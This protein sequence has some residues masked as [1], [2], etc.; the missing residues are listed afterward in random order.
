MQ[1]YFTTFIEYILIINICC[2][3]CE[4]EENL[5][6]VTIEDQIN[7]KELVPTQVPLFYKTKKRRHKEISNKIEA[8][9]ICLKRIRSNRIP[10]K[11]PAFK[12]VLK[13]NRQGRGSPESSQKMSSQGA[14]DE[15]RDKT[16][17]IE[18]AVRS[19]NKVCVNLNEIKLKKDSLTCF[20]NELD[21]KEDLA[22][23]SKSHT[24]TKPDSF[25]CT[26]CGK[27]FREK[28]HLAT[29]SRAH[30][31]IRNFKCNEC[32]G[33]FKTKTNLFFHMK[34]HEEAPFI[35]DRCN[36]TFPERKI[37]MRHKRVVHR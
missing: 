25:D 12:K 27:K 2:F 26:V 14:S 34:T 6:N 28:S 3:S 8:N 9:E 1:F 30:V 24:G 35:C 36:K 21:S 31:E 15:N 10:G 19:N 13:N 7:E 4:V 23:H 22:A 5:E 11:S 20:Q 16:Y 33:L 29:H 37:L 32:G 18:P 17:V